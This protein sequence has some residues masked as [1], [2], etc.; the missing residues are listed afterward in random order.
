MKHFMQP[1][2]M[3]LREAQLPIEP[4][5]SSNPNSS[6]KSKSSSS[7][8]KYKSSSKE[9]APPPSDLN[10]FPTPFSTPSPAV[11]KLKSPLPP[12]PPPSNPLKRKLTMDALL[13]KTIPCVSD[14]GVKV[15]VRMR[16]PNKDEETG[17][18][19][20]QKSSNDSLSINGQ[21]FT[22][23][24]VADTV[25]TQLDIFQLVGAP[26][27]EN[28]LAGFN[29]SV[30]AYGQTGSGKTYTMWGPANAL[31]EENLLS[32]QQ[33]LTPRV[34]Q[35]LFT[36]ISEEQT[37]HADKQLK[38]QCRCSF[39]EI[40][41]EQITDLLDPN[42]RNLQIRE[43]VKSGV[44]VENLTE[45]YVCTMKDVT[46]LLIKGLSNRR[47]GATSI[48]A[49]SSRSHSVFTCV[50]ESRCKSMTDGVR[51]LKTSRINLV[52]LAGSERQKLTGAAG[53]RLKEAGNINRS[54]S[55][56]GNLINILAEVSQTGKQRHIPY[57]D[58]KLTFLLQESLG[59]NAK[60]V[61]VCAICPAQSCKSETFSTLRFAQRAKAIKNKAE[62]N[63]EMQDD[64][65]SLREIIRQL[66]DELNRMKANGNNPT[67]TNGGLSAGW[68]RM[69]LN[70]IKQSL[71]HPSMLNVIDDDSDEEMEIDEEA[72]E[73]L[74]VE[75]KSSS[76]FTASENDHFDKPQPCT[77]DSGGVH[78]IDPKD[79]DVNMEEGLCEQF[80]NHD[81]MLVDYNSVS[82]NPGVNDK[83]NTVHLIVEKLN[84]DSSGCSTEEKKPPSV[85]VCKLADE[86]F[87]SEMVGVGHLCSASDPLGRV[88]GGASVADAANDS[89]NGSV[90]CA[91]P[92]GLMIIP[93][94]VSLL[95]SPTPSVSPRIND[96][97]KSL[98]TSSML[99]A[100][101]IDPND[102]S[103]LDTDAVPL[104]SMKSMKCVSS[105]AMHRQAL[106]NFL[107]P[108]ENLAASLYRGLEIIDGQ[109]QSSSMRRSCFRFSYKPADSQPTLSIDKVNVGV[110]TSTQH[111]ELPEDSEAFLCS[112]CKSRMQLEV[113]ET[114]DS[115]HLQLVPVDGSESAEKSKKQVP[116]AVEK[117]LAG[118]IRREMALEELCAKQ[119]S[120]IMQLNRLVQQY[121]HE[122]ECNAIIGQTREDKILRFEGLMDGILPTEEFMEEE[123]ASLTHEHKLLKEKFENHP[124]VLRTKIE[125]KRVQDE[126]E[127]YQN[128][129]DMGE[130]EV[131]LEEI[132]DLRSQL[133]Y[134]IDT[135]STSARKR[136]SLLQL[137]YSCDAN[138]S[139]SLKTIPESTGESAEE[140]LEQERIYWTEAESKWISLAD[141]MRMELDASR[142]LAELRKQE[143]DTEKRCAEE[144]K[145]AMQ[146]AME[147]HARM[148]E[149]YADL[150]EKHIQLLARH[151]KIQE[152]ID[153][154]KKAA[155]KAG[156][157]GAESKFLNALAAEISALKAE[158]EKERRYFRDEIKGLQAQLRDTAEAV[159]AAGELLVRLKEAEEAVAASQKQAMEAEQETVAAYKE[160]DKLKRKHEHEINTLNERLAESHLPKQ[161]LQPAYNESDMAK[162]NAGGTHS[163]GE[164]QW[165]EE[166]EPFYKV[167]DGELSKLTEP[168]SWFSGYDRC[169]I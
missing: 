61:M 58:S 53:E 16:P 166:F 94:D 132:Q 9:N 36:R 109:H 6:S 100:S 49:E 33:G 42:Q 11:S 97:R 62:I 80:E 120:E 28:C 64:V 2:N 50:V 122:R 69:S 123:L 162:Y 47:T 106:K 160:I 4:Q 56:L 140:K 129:Y 66:K 24:S 30:F 77:S 131:L 38:Y 72:V 60:L 92:R 155:T 20:V 158:R 169:N 54:L 141:E 98:R 18:I 37:K 12:R 102:D 135:T 44:Y 67:G 127:R 157:R 103:K 81:L 34:F 117:V 73:K 88:S 168:S 68:A 31:L 71:S 159:Q 26:L 86:G 14:S 126:L 8:R 55:Q 17:E 105:K 149:Q 13:E 104:P 108:T 75:V 85:S 116:K 70:L 40:Y 95:K 5:S 147:G 148:L 125:L 144:L 46:Q 57:R 136:T 99:T 121:K 65:N 7:S 23:D 19:I 21:A 164:Q 163:E 51:R 165:R 151:R 10:S 156:V 22:F 128:F 74:C 161:T 59:G 84:G 39:L 29:S 137:T 43:D 107:E 45:D 142:S 133:Q 111:N 143:L 52:D 83:G 154:V 130:K 113:K 27:V 90:P 87:P 153:D 110:Q 82:N 48:N 25:A 79:T 167:E 124:E 96:S 93:D 114:H 134:Y 32:D 76:Q 146:M 63:E 152:G 138:I 101:Q 119:T 89:E 145:E 91:S 139:P 150:Q 112:S 35:E 15:I 115:S 118:S 78:E 1:R 3:V 41:N